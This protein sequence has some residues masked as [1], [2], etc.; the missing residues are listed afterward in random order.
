VFA[1]SRKRSGLEPARSPDL[2]RCDIYSWGTL[3]QKVYRSNTYRIEEL[4][5][6]IRREV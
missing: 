4:K 2:D 6:N 3:K 1:D 5:E